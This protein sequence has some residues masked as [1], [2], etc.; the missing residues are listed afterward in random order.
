M[1]AGR[2]GSIEVYEQAGKVVLVIRGHYTTERAIDSARRTLRALESLGGG[3]FVADFSEA[4]GFDTDGR[5][6]W[7]TRLKELRSL[8]RTIY[9]VN[10]PPLMRMAATA[11]CL[12]AG[13]K[14][15][16]I[17]A[18]EGAFGAAPTTRRAS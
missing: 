8:V 17:D 15:R 7:Q 18:V 10:G 9:I 4:T 16:S 2:P 12:Y 6:H 1:A 5:V 14:L 13:I 11:V 3:D